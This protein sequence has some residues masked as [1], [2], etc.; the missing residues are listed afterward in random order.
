MPQETPQNS[1]QPRVKERKKEN[2]EKKKGLI[3]KKRKKINKGKK[4]PRPRVRVCVGA[5][6]GKIIGGLKEGIHLQPFSLLGGRGSA[7]L[8]RL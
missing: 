3:K 5:L 7:A 8:G 2:K 4:K 1:F 6:R